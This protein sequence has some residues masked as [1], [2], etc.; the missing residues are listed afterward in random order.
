MTLFKT[1]KCLAIYGFKM[2][3]KINFN[4]DIGGKFMQ[5]LFWDENLFKRKWEKLHEIKF[6]FYSL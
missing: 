6:K 1:L 3:I 5:Y 4:L 2:R